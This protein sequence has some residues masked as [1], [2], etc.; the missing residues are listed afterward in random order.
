MNDFL[1]WLAI[2]LVT[3]VLVQLFD[4]YVVNYR[5]YRLSKPDSEE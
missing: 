1:Y 4:I 2:G 3:I 5:R